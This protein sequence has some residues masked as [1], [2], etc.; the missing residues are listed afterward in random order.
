[1]LYC[2]DTHVC[3]VGTCVMT[4]PV[5]LKTFP[6]RANRFRPLC[7]EHAHTGTA[8]AC[9]DTHSLPGQLDPAVLLH[10]QSHRCCWGCWEMLLPFFWPLLAGE[11]LACSNELCAPFVL[12]APLNPAAS[13]GCSDGAGGPVCYLSLSPVPSSQP[14]GS[15]QHRGT[16]EQAGQN[17]LLAATRPTPLGSELSPPPTGGQSLSRG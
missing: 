3:L 15:A 13:K 8:A 17:L 12:I 7:H 5:C 6:V 4:F 10:W 1:M 2:E 9:G 11:A 16:L 14:W